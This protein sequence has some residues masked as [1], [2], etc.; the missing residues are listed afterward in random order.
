MTCVVYGAL[1]TLIM[2]HYGTLCLWDIW[3][4]IIIYLGHYYIFGTLLYIWD[5][6]NIYNIMKELVT[7]SWDICIN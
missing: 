7:F 3:D 6:I 5:N 2:G 4:I 1:D